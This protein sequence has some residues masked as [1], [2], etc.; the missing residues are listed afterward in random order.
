MWLALALYLGIGV[1]LILLA[2]HF[3]LLPD[4]N[5]KRE[6]YGKTPEAR[7]PIMS[8]YQ[9]FFSMQDEVFAFMDC[10]GLLLIAC[11]LTKL[12]NP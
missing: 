2:E 4:L 3:I 8:V 10:V 5:K 12:L 9:R 7:A 6:K 11:M 1:L